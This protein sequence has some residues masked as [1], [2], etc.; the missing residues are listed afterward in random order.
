MKLTGRRYPG[1]KIGKAKVGERRLQFGT[2]EKKQWRF[3]E[4]SRR[5][6]SDMDHKTRGARVSEREANE[7][8]AATWRWGA[9]DR[10]DCTQG[11]ALQSPFILLRSISPGR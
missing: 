5:E 8:T 2:Q 3:G 7:S 6:P 1:K 9:F 10:F 4:W 11:Q